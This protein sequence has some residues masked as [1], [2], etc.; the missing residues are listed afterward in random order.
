M[1]DIELLGI[2][3]FCVLMENNDGIKSKHRDYINEKYQLIK[4]PPHMFSAL[5]SNN[6]R[7]VIEWGKS[8]GINFELL[9]EQIQNDYNNIPATEFRKKYYEF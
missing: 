9:T 2:V 8:W 3:S 7:K 5:D 1:N 4:Y 6:Q